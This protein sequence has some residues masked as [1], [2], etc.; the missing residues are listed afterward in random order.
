MSY[1]YD[2]FDSIS[3]QKLQFK[4]SPK[5]RQGDMSINRMD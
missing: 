3:A 2:S 5:N 1:C 4:E